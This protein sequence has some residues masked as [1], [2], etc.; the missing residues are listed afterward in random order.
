MLYRDD[1]AREFVLAFPGT[2]GLDDFLTDVEI[3]GVPYLAHAVVCDGCN[4]VLGFQDAWNTVFDILQQPLQQALKDY[5]FYTLTITG[6]SLGGAIAQ[7]AYASLV[8][9]GGYRV[10]KGVTFGQPRV[11]NDKYAAF[12]DKLAGASDA[13]PGNF[14]RVTHANGSSGD[15]S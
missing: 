8:S 15:F 9:D 12:I 6:H 1:G 3:V 4:V 7:L 11:G 2:D 5:P 14:Y 13:F 10:T